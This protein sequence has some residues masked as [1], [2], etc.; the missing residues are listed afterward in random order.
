MGMFRGD[1][2]NE[3]NL[4]PDGFNENANSADSETGN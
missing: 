4:D 1:N 3:E 2:G